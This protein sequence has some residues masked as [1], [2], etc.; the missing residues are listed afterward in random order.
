MTSSGPLP[1]VLLLGGGKMGGA[2]LNGWRRAGL[3]PSYVL[4]PGPTAAGLAGDLV[5]VVAEAASIP[6]G[7]RPDAV[8]LAV[9]PQMAD[10][11]LP[12]IAPFAAEALVVSIMAG[13]TSA[14]IAN[15]TGASAIVRAMPN[16]PAAIGQGFTAAFAGPG[17]SAA[18]RSLCDGLLQSIGEVAWVEDESQLDA[19]TATSGSGPAYVFLLAELLEA[20]AIEQGLPPDLARR[21]ARRTV[22]GSGALLAAGTDDAAIMRQAV[23]SPGGT[24]QAALGVL[25]APA[26]WPD[27]MSRAVAAATARSR[28]LSS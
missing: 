25:M 16:T 19:I 3:G 22:A 1:S 5:A 17:V 4:D 28:E 14:G 23:T 10:V 24:T 18:Q 7:F 8:V 27:A 15:L 13:R 6:A 9:K 11:A 26:A 21:L 12:G 20:A 2:M